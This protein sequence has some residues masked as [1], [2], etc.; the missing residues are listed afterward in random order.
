VQGPVLWPTP[1]IH[2]EIIKKMYFII[3]SFVYFNTA[4]EGLDR[5][6]IIE[7][8][9][10]SIYVNLIISDRGVRLILYKFSNLI[11]LFT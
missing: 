6:K 2:T 9:I 11:K 8:I 7:A 3:F 1:Y 4:F 10:K 5:K